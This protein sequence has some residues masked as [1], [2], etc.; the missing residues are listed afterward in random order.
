MRPLVRST[1]A[2]SVGLLVG[3]GTAVLAVGMTGAGDG[4]NSAPVSC[5]SL[6]GAPLAAVAWTASVRRM[7]LLWATVALIGGLCID[8]LLCYETLAEG[9]EYATRAWQHE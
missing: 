1:I 3:L 9:L 6:V 7:S 8:A 2:A 4:W 5:A